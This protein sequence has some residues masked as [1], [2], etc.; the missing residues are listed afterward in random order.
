MKNIGMN[1]ARSAAGACTPTTTA[2]VPMTA[3]S[4]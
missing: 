4:E 1:D 3:A 2:R